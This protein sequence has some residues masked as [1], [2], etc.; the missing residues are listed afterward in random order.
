M[1]VSPSVVP[2]AWSRYEWWASGQPHMNKQELE[3]SPENCMDRRVHCARNLYYSCWIFESYLYQFVLA[4]GQC[5][6]IWRRA[7]L[8]CTIIVGF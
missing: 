1:Y 3:H 5:P 4:V 2:L 7:L 8:V 6:L